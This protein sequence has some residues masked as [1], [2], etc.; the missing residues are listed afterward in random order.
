MALFLTTTGA[1]VG[2]AETLHVS[3]AGRDTWSGQLAAPNAQ[4][5]DGPLASLTGARDA[6]R[7]I[8]SAGLLTQPIRVIIADGTYAVSQPI[9][10]EPVDSGTDAFPISYEAAPGARPI[11]NGGYEI[12]GWTRS[13]NC[14]WT[15]SIP[16]TRAGQP[17]FEQLFVNGRRATRAR[18]PNQWY[19]Y[20]LAP[21]ASAPDPVSG[22]PT[23]MFHRAF[24]ARPG[25]VKAWPDLKDALVTVF[26]SW[27]VIRSHIADYD[28][29]TGRVILNES[30]AYP[31]GGGVACPRYIVEN[32]REALD[33]PGEWHLSRDHTLSY[34]PLPDEDM[35][36]AEV[37]APFADTFVQF[38]G[39]PD[40]GEFVENITLD[41]LRFLYADYRLGG[42]DYRGVQAA[43]QIPAV[44]M[45]DGARHVRIR[46]C[47]I[48][49]VGSYGI[50]FRNGCRD[51]RV[52]RNYL[53]ALGAGG[54]R[55][56]DGS[57]PVATAQ[58][59]GN[60]VVD[61]NIIRDGGR[62]F[63]SAVGVWI[64]QA[65]D[66]RITHNEI[67][68]FRYTGVSV[69][70]TWGYGPS[71][72]VR[73]TIDLN[74][75]HHIGW[76]VLSDMGAVYTL[77]RSAGTTVSHNLIHDIYSYDYGGW[78]LYNDE[79][80]SYILMENNLVYNTKTGGYHQH[81]GRENTLRNNIFALAIEHQLQRTRIEPHRSFT[82]AQNIVYY[83]QGKLLESNWADDQYLSGSNLFWNTSGL[84]TFP[85][86]QNLIAW[87]KAGKEAGST[88]A[89]P[90]FVDPANGDFR[91][92]PGSPAASI[93][94]KPF[95]P[96]KA[97]VYGQQSWIALANDVKYPPIQF[98]PTPP[99][100]P[101]L[102][103]HEDFEAPPPQA[104]PLQGAVSADGSNALVVVTDKMAAS[105]RQSL[106]LQDSPA[107]RAAYLPL[108]SYRPKHTSGITRLSFDVR[109]GP[110]AC[111]GHDWRDEASPYNSG[112]RL[113][114]CDGK[115]QV[116]GQ[117]PVE[118]PSDRWVRIQIVSR[119]GKDSTGTWDLTVNL[120]EPLADVQNDVRLI[121]QPLAQWT[122]LKYVSPAFR[123]LRWFGFISN[124]TKE[125]E[126]YLD[127]V[128]LTNEPQ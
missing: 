82:F 70:W 35:T 91:L 108:I 20:I 44:I 89:A 26:E 106:K 123:E 99:P 90:Q 8:K 118:I 112:A 83:T 109:L 11:I 42:G 113:N 102:T 81:Y 67:A 69:G 22:K 45:A 47:E 63:P 65:G 6:V 66:N 88:V 28:P 68:D 125:S 111:L 57:V 119:L 56:G 48:A 43:Y 73:N 116:T 60:I 38:A 39:K 24:I 110:G 40:K 101:P 75:I 37:I 46:D 51:C 54:V 64:A 78:G 41:G 76:G 105:G 2:F 23:P 104:Q 80:S 72:A 79:G 19:H 53:H 127:N 87:Q 27:E 74:H 126:I 59:T 61:N 95:D 30:T 34:V 115:L 10:F 114:I 107:L 84:V 98:A 12:T 9:V 62:V 120:L 18:S 29:K 16:Q 13:T 96:A 50:W 103:L 92:K 21:V 117:P 94:F 71:L 7:R 52:E 121:A 49:H 36:K 4:G 15:T 25:D 3:P 77:G 100:M 31:L 58:P 55:I 32:V 85:S 124:A 97:G 5:S 14:I 17:A 33:A 93:G 128:E 1:A 86:N 122:G